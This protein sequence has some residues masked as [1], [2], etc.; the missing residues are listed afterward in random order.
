M[1]AASDVCSSE[2]TIKVDKLHGKAALG[3]LTLLSAAPRTNSA[4]KDASVEGGRTL[5]CQRQGV[6]SRNNTSLELRWGWVTVPPP[7]DSTGPIV[8]HFLGV[9][10]GGMG[11][12]AGFLRLSLDDEMSW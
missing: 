3:F 1:A 2:H 4:R 8:G 5:T 12:A 9:V 10:W 11:V 6:T 7:I